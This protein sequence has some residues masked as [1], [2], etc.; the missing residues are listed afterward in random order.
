MSRKKLG[1]M[2]VVA[3]LALGSLMA[4]SAFAS[5]TETT[6]S[7]KVEGTTLSGSAAVSC[8][9]KSGTSITLA[10]SLGGANV[11]L[12]ATGVECVE[13]TIFNEGGFARDAGKL[14]FTGVTVVEPA[15]CKTTA[16]LSTKAL[17]TQLFMEGTTTY[18]KF[19]PAS[20]E[21]FI[22]IPI[23]ECG[24]EGSY[25]VTGF[26]Y[27]KSSNATGVSATSQTLTFGSAVN[28]SAGNGLKLGGNEATISAEVENS[29]TSGKAFSA[30]E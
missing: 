12:N 14:K 10:G 18:D 6:G 25:P 23:T 19:A 9:V 17:K 7:W 13:S 28:A 27:G 8:H 21:T 5:P 24:A 11:K 1:S 30:S 16:S 2:L 3:A 20:G 4:A 22:S 15:G 26:V 29:L